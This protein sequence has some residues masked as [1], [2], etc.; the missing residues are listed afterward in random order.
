MKKYADIC[1]AV[2]R[3][4]KKYDERN[5]YLLCKL[6]KIEILYWNF[7]TEDNAI[8]GFYYEKNRCK[9]IILN[10]SLPECVRRIIIAHELGHSILHKGYALKGFREIIMYD[11]SVITEKEANLFAAELLLDDDEVLDSME[12]YNNFM[13][14]ASVLRVPA[15]LLCYKFNIMDEKG[16]DM[17]DV[18]MYARAKFLKDLEMP[19]SYEDWE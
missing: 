13:E 5:I 14:M 1:Q 4:T 9:R 18:P 16:Y 10:N 11:E 6:L 7:G 12:N 8:K 2:E 19:T 3:L 15:E 17:P